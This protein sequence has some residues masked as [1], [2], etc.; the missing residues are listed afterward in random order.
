MRR[1]VVHVPDAASYAPVTILVDERPDGIHLSY[2]TMASYLAS[3]GS[4]D[5]LEV[6]V[7]PIARL[8][9]F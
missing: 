8:R 3:Y 5:A 7:D 4:S 1:M 9:L 2:D 6:A